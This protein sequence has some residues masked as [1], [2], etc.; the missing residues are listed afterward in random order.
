M[1]RKLWFFL[2]YEN[3]FKNI[4]RACSECTRKQKKVSY[5]TDWTFPDLIDTFGD[6]WKEIKTQTEKKICIIVKTILLTKN[7][8]LVS[9][10]WEFPKDDTER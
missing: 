1:S 9:N 4:A 8:F 5:N 3:I 6:D 2:I 7:L 10:F